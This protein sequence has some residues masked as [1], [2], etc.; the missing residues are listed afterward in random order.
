MKDFRML[1]VWELAHRLTLDI[2]HVTQKFSKEEELGLKSQISRSS[3]SIT[4]NL[5]EGSGRFT[6]ADFAS[7]LS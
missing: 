5:A 3:V 2:Y 4:N 1:N 7:M 6:D